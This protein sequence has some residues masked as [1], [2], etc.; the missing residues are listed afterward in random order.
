MRRLRWKGKYATGVARVDEQ[1]RSLVETFN[2]FVDAMGTSEHCQD[3]TDLA[4]RLA[5]TI[6]GSLADA[7]RSQGPELYRAQQHQQVRDLAAAGLPLAARDGPA[8]KDCA[9][10]DDLESRLTDWLDAHE[11]SSDTADDRRRADAA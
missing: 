8:C 7:D 11:T 4:G 1:C 3:M 5:E 6:E 10:C 9:L 2:G